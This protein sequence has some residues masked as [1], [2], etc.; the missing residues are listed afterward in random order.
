[1]AWRSGPPA[2]RPA[3]GA[4]E[5][6]PPGRTRTATVRGEGVPQVRCWCSYQNFL[7][8]PGWPSADRL[9]PLMRARHQ[10]AEAIHAGVESEEVFQH[11]AKEE[12]AASG[13]LLFVEGQIDERTAREGHTVFRDDSREM[14]LAGNRGQR[15]EEHTSELPVTFL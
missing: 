11:R 4:P 6:A 3:K 8:G 13:E 12:D 7:A 14:T 5:A 1:M 10:L 2:C 15:S 9:L